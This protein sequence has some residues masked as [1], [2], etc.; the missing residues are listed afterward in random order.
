MRQSIFLN[1]LFKNISPTTFTQKYKL[2][3]LNTTQRGTFP[4]SAEFCY[5]VMDTKTVLLLVLFQ[6]MVNVI[7]DVAEENP[8]FSR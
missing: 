1:F 3:S 7:V 6:G 4:F 2:S 5:K 8:K